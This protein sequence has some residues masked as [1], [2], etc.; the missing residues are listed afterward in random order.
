[1]SDVGE[2]ELLAIIFT[3]AVDSTAR[4]AS[5]EDY[6]L[7]ILLADLDYMRN[8]AA[9]RGGTV[10][11]NTGDG[12]LISFKSAVDAVECALSIQKGFAN[13]AENAAFTH[14]I[15]VHIGDVI[16]KDGD[17]YGSGV[18]TASRLVAQCPAGGLCMSSTLYE[19]V[20]QKSQIGKLKVENFQVTNI[21]PPIKA[22]RVRAIQEDQVMPVA[23]RAPKHAVYKT[24][25]LPRKLKLLF[26]ISVVT[27]ILLIIFISLERHT[28]I[29]LKV[30]ADPTLHSF[31]SKN[32]K[33]HY[34]TVREFSARIA[35]ADGPRELRASTF[36]LLAGLV[37]GQSFV[38]FESLEYPGHFL[39]HQDFMIK[40]HQDDGSDEFKKTATFKKVDGLSDLSSASFE[41]IDQP[42]HF[43]RHQNW[44]LRLQRSEDSDLFRGDSTFS[45]VDPLTQQNETLVQISGFPIPSDQI[46]SFQGKKYV[47]I[48]QNNQW[49]DANSVAQEMGGHLLTISSQ[50]EQE[51]I[52]KFL[53]SQKTERP[54]SWLGISDVLKEGQ[55]RWVTGEEVVYTNWGKGN[56]D[57]WGGIQHYA[58]IGLPSY[59]EGQWDDCQESMSLPFVVEFEKESH[60]K[61]I[62]NKIL[63]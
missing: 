56:P 58:W 4:T 7:R 62:L 24:H 27:G 59:P 6:S 43:M 48:S 57:N 26:G 23:T 29:N 46:S 35:T 3:D 17:I 33:N 30:F 40:L 45:V 31:E 37:S 21:E 10:L 54:I 49:R 8:E 47:F 28:D 2:R 55:W 34:I 41:S 44:L 20:K 38:S 18:N 52:F 9:V 25:G 53:K 61:K 19:L 11:K 42:N 16:K 51:F 36:R 5:D 60:L 12:L 13:R 14:K 1:M 15:G 50:D 63:K 39:R 22:Y 32:Y